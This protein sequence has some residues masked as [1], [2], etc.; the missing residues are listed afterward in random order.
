MSFG[1]R[2]YSVGAAVLTPENSQR[3]TEVDATRH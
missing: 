1:V 3:F 2:W